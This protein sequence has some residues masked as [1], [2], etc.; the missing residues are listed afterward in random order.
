MG[1][2]IGNNNK[3]KNSNIAEN[4]TTSPTDEKKGVFNKH[5]WLCGILVSII[6]GLILMFSFWDNIITYIERWF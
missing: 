4:M 1:I 2:N 6:A 5:P 3:I